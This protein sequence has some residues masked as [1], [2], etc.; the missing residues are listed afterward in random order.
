FRVAQ[1][2][3]PEERTTEAEITVE[4]LKPI[5]VTIT[6]KGTEI[7]YFGGGNG[8]QED[9]YKIATKAHFLEFLERAST[10]DFIDKYYEQISDINLGGDLLEPA[11]PSADVAFAGVYD[12]KGYKLTGLKVNSTAT[13]NA[14]TG[15]IARY[16]TGATFKN[17]NYVGCDIVGNCNLSTGGIVGVA[18]NVTIENCTI[19]GAI[20]SSITYCGG[21]VGNALG[22]TI[23][24]CK[25]LEDSAV[26]TMTSSAAGIAAIINDGTVVED[27]EV[28]GKISAKNSYAGGICAYMN[29]GVIR[30]CVV[31]SLSGVTAYKTASHS[32]GIVGAIES[33]KAGASAIIDGCS[34]FC[35]VSCTDSGGGLVGY[36]NPANA[37]DEFT[38]IN[39]QFVGGEVVSKSQNSSAYAV[40]G[41]GFGWVG[42]NKV[43]LGTVNL[44]NIY[45]APKIVYGGYTAIDASKL[46]TGGC[47]GSFIGYESDITCNII[48]CY[49][50]TSINDLYFA[51]YRVLD[52]GLTSKKFGFAGQTY[53]SKVSV[54]NSAWLD[55][56]TFGLR[57]ST[58]SSFS[59]ASSELSE[60]NM[61]N[62]TLLARLN[63]G[64]AAYNAKNTGLTARS[65]VAGPDGYPVPSGL[66]QNPAPGTEGKIRV[67]V[68]GDSI[69][70]YISYIPGGYSTYYPTADVTSPRYTY[71]YRLV[72]DNMTNAVLDKNIAWS[73]SLVAAAP[74]ETYSTEHWW[75]HDFVARFIERGMGNPD[76]I[77]IHGGTNDTG[78]RGKNAGVTLLGSYDVSGAAVPSDVEFE[79]VYAKVDGAAT[80]ADLEALPDQTFIEAYCKLLGL[81][82]QQYPNAKVVMIIG[83]WI[84]SGAQKS[85]IK[86]QQHYGSLYGY[87]VV[88]LCT[89][90]GYKTS[91]KIDKVEAGN[92]HPNSAGH[93]A[94]AD[95]IFQQVGSY[96]NTK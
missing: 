62:G 55:D 43:S 64:A 74:N 14:P 30:N 90:S 53:A 8:T 67:S 59:V 24:N 38:I 34:V 49:T 46:A 71:W 39:C 58:L 45:V 19:H 42:K 13:E 79:A 89:W 51:T 76:V 27:C 29:D 87:K 54:S 91:T 75:N 22:C 78:S 2:E 28:N 17:I 60:T 32:G 23:K 57:Q 86:I 35:D 65:W 56:M 10:A 26:S 11:C 93:K 5:V 36:L 31:S 72:Y 52:S 83:D 96:I 33:K 84:P 9:P 77:L 48:S 4:S 70:T 63:E 69:S 25:L 47:V 88:D 15:G 3:N 66:P 94:M 61:K 68:I 20:S 21:F 16:A 6:Q 44:V 40:L 81:M 37:N 73:G 95:Y 92:C 85:L 7:Y 50:P 82:H 18:T 41:G 12:G 1:N 80:R